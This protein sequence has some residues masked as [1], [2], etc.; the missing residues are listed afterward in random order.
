MLVFGVSRSKRALYFSKYI[1]LFVRTYV[2]LY[3]DLRR[4]VCLLLNL[5]FDLNLNL[6][7]NRFPNLNLNLILFQKPFERSNPLSLRSTSGFGNR[8][9]PVQVGVAPR[10]KTLP[11]GR[12]L[13]ADYLTCVRHQ[14]MDNTEVMSQVHSPLF[15]Q[16]FSPSRAGS[17][18][19]CNMADEMLD[20]GRVRAETG[21]LLGSLERRRRPRSERTGRDLLLRAEGQ[22]QDCAETDAAGK[23][24]ST[25]T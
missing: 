13:Y 6:N 11:Q 24:A 4:H 16:F 15:P 2:G 22:R 3:R 14:P 20:A 18:M 1:S 25:V 9:L 10:P 21:F 5:A 17:T 12:P 19:K 7:L 8:S 23:V